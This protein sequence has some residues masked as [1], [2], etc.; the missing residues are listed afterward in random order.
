MLC[1][2]LQARFA[3]FRTFTA[4]NF[5]PTAGFITPSAAY[6]LLLNVAG[7]ETRQEHPKYPMTLIR[8]ALPRFRLAMGARYLPG[9]QSLYQQL[10]NYP[11]GNT[12][13]GRAP[14]TQGNKY[15]IVPVRRSLLTD[16]RAYLCL[17]GG[18]AEFE[19]QVRDGLTGKRPRSYGLPFLGD[20]NF[21][22]D[23]LEVVDK[24]QPTYWF[25]RLGLG[26]EDNEEGTFHQKNERCAFH[27]KR[28]M[29]LTIY[30]NRED[31]S[32][33]RSDL[34]APGRVKTDESPGHTWLEKIPERA[35]VEVG[36]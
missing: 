6:G 9:Q 31:M 21:L 11:V 29:R 14:R 13:K 24:P 25:E 23:R 8:Q 36:H 7:I 26:D 32:K 12:G 27:Q 16:L 35:W 19:E 1:I 18:S 10:H 15:N 28:V 30:I 17:D 22:I 2:Y 34:F 20:N 4:G 33:T 5:R 3:V